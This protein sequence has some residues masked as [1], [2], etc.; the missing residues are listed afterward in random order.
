MMTTSNIDYANIATCE[1]SF[2]IDQ[3]CKNKSAACFADGHLSGEVIIDLDSERLRALSFS[4]FLSRIADRRETLRRKQCGLSFNNF[5]PFSPLPLIPI[6]SADR[7]L[8]SMLTFVHC[9]DSKMI[10]EIILLLAFVVAV[11]A[12]IVKAYEWRQD[13]LYGPYTHENETE[14]RP[15]GDIERDKPGVQHL[16]GRVASGLKAFL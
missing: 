16:V 5:S 4:D 11:G 1:H 9:G 3:T 2:A 6:K 8:G 12:V 13:V 15:A 7:N 14:F 10:I